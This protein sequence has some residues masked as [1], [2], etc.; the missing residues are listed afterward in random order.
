MSISKER[1]DRDEKIKSALDD[2]KNPYYTYT[3]DELIAV[4][5]QSFP[6]L[7]TWP[8][9]LI[10]AM[11][12]RLEGKEPEGSLGKLRI[13]IME[14]ADIESTQAEMIIALL[15]NKGIIEFDEDFNIK[16]KGSK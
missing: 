16:T 14:S 12:D 9:N 10:S 6:R 5:R 13:E 7:N 2:T 4:A 11:V 8:N 3:S 1:L 15:M